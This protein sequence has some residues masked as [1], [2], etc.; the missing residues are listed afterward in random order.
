MGPASSKVGLV[1]VLAFH[2]CTGQVPVHGGA[3]PR[4]L[5][6][7]DEAPVLGLPLHSNTG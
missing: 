5:H 3:V 6:R 2:H 7:A 1:W 4:Q